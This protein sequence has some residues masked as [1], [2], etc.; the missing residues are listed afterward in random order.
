MDCDDGNP[1]TDDCCITGVGCQH[2]QPPQPCDLLGVEDGFGCPGSVVT[3]TAML[4]NDGDCREE[5]I[6]TVDPAGGSPPIES[7]SAPGSVSV[8][9]H[10]STLVEITVTLSA[11]A[12]PNDSATVT[13]T[14]TSSSDG[15]CGSGQSDGCSDQA[16]VTVIRPDLTFLG[17]SE[18][19]EENPGGFLALNDDDDNENEI[20]DKDETGPTA[21]EDDLRSLTLSVPLELEGTIT[22]SCTSGCSKVKLYENA[23]RTNPVSLPQSWT[24]PGEPFPKVFYVEG[25]A[26]SARMRDVSLK[27]AFEGEGGPGE[28]PVKLTVIDVQLRALTFTS[29][30]GL[31]LD[32]NIDYEPTGTLF[33][34]PEWGPAF[35]PPRNYPISHTMDSHV[36]VSAIITVAPSDAPAFTYRIAGAA[37][38]AGFNFDAT[39]SLGGGLNFPELTSTDTIEKDIQVLTP[40]IEW[41]ITR[42]GRSWAEER[43]GLHTVYVTMGTPRDTYLLAHVVTQKRMARAVEQ[44]SAA[45]SLN[46]H[47]IV[48]TVTWAQGNFSL[49]GPLP[50]AWL[51]PDQPAPC[52]SIVRFVGKV[53]KMVNVPGTFA[54]KTIYAIETAPSDAIEQSDMHAGLNQDVRHHPE[55]PS[56]QLF[57]ID[58]NGG[59]NA[60]EA[61]AKFNACSELRYYPGGVVGAF[62]DNK[63]NVLKVFAS[64]SWTEWVD[65]VCTVREEVFDYPAVPDNPSVPDCP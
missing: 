59:C 45:N 54:H 27:V 32:N 25:F 63:D 37:E 60:F 41:L 62:M 42:D 21:G 53:V 65:D 51:V 12:E 48:R 34:E 1:C 6:L 58:G 55:H 16:S 39:V 22:L 35:T 3:L 64:L 5:Y 44:A 19:Q 26:P 40:A 52:E 49:L 28:D 36:G 50:N 10:S 47:E 15:T 24:V 30:H 18:E 17:V 8:E 9:G 61:V 7:T 31:M 33:G 4:F 29:D 57:L 46:S 2:D 13:L 38:V 43:T 20:L 11:D 23:N 56:W 14:A